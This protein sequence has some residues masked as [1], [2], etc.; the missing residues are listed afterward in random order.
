[1]PDRPACWGSRVGRFTVRG[2]LAGS[3]E[4]GIGSAPQPISGSYAG[5]VSETGTGSAFGNRVVAPSPI[6]PKIPRAI[7]A[8]P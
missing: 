1:M 6:S 8:M 4:R 2:I 3:P 5:P 7:M